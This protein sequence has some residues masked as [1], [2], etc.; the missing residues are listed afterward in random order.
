MA[1]I[2]TLLATVGTGAAALTNVSG[3]V[4]YDEGGIAELDLTAGLVGAR[5]LWA[6]GFGGR[7]VDVA[8]IDTGITPVLGTGRIYNG[9]DLS[10]DAQV[11]G[12][13]YLDAYGH[14]THL[15]S[16]IN[17]S[18]PGVTA[19][20][21]SACR[22]NRINPT[23]TKDMG[24]PRVS[25]FAGMAP[26]ARVVNLKTGAADGAVDVTQVIA[27]IDWAV[28]N[29]NRNGLNIR[30]LAIP[31]GV[32]STQIY[33][34]DPLSHAVD[35]AAANGILV[36]AAAGND[37]TTDTALAY[38]ARN[39][40][41]LAV[42]AADRGSSSS[43]GTD[44]TTW[45]VASFSDRGT[46]QRKPDLLV[47]AVLIPG[48][49]VPGSYLDTQTTTQGNR[50]IRGSGTSQATAIV[51]GVAAQ[52][53]QRY[54]GATVPQLKDMLVTSSWRARPG[55]F[56]SDATV[57]STNKLLGARPNLA[58]PV[59]FVNTAGTASVEPLR[60]AGTMAIGEG[61]LT[62]DID[63]QG[64]SMAGWEARAT[65]RTSWSGGSWMGRVYTGTPTSTGVPAAPWAS[66]W[67]GVPWSQVAGFAGTWDGLRWKGDDWSGL[68]WKGETWSGLRW[69]GV[70]WDGLRWKGTNW[71]GLRW[72]GSANW[73]SASWT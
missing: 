34:R 46:T 27:Q 73:S 11:G 28:Q 36:V 24:F 21:S 57:L 39:R 42:G 35:V 43:T 14:G 1:A 7:G 72:K 33:F 49:R 30:V 26:D 67:A 41:V 62:G 65:A 56:V 25:G 63:V 38:P 20:P 4:T 44:V 23:A 13:P 61:R 2:G 68:R 53:A 16:L 17:G 40:D 31:Y 58:L 5:D 29:R 50:L 70:A 15:A 19:P 22:S 45:T 9:P 48:L 54:P 71:D 3:A 52:L 6:C 32:S 37:G 8:L 12:A 10:F 59:P 18:D 55:R 47:P 69:K 66:S 64:R 51:A 60:S